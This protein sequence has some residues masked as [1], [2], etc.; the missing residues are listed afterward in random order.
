MHVILYRLTC[1][2]CCDLF[3][4]LFSEAEATKQTISITFRMIR[5]ERPCGYANRDSSLI[6]GTFKDG[7]RKGYRVASVSPT[8][9]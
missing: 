8:F 7:Y 9:S 4:R 5:R 2:G 6:T 1:Y 3:P